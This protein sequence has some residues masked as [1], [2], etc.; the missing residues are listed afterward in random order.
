MTR[1]G[2]DRLLLR[3]A[4]RIYDALMTTGREAVREL[5]RTSWQELEE[6]HQR[7]EQAVTRSWTHAAAQ[8]RWEIEHSLTYLI[9]Q[10]E[11]SRRSLAGQ[12]VPDRLSTPREI[13]RELLALQAEFNGVKLDLKGRTLSVATDAIVLEQV[14]LGR[15]E[16]NL[17]WDR[18]DDEDPYEVIG[19]DPHSTSA[20]SSTTHPHVRDERL[21]EGDGRLPIRHALAQGRLCDFFVLVRQILE[22]YNP[23]S[24]FVSL[25]HW[26]G[27]PCQDCGRVTD[28]DDSTS[29]EHCSDNLCLDCS[30]SCQDCGSGVCADCRSTCSGCDQGFCT[31]CLECCTSCRGDFCANCGSN[32]RCTTCKEKEKKLHEQIER[33]S[34]RQAAAT[35]CGANAPLESIRLGEAHAPA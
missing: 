29:C 27:T 28:E 35:E 17:H 8:V 2:K 15:F 5:P 23:S 22:T 16:I 30:T 34:S 21:C 19:L 24:A 4:M 13:H 1:P 6:I 7:L 11:D 3:G 25:E 31:A 33:P 18:L 26:N 9:R 32:G 20:D 14:Y 10:L 12:H